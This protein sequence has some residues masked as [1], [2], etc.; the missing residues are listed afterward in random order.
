MALQDR[1]EVKMSILKPVESTQKIS[2]VGQKLGDIWE[3]EQTLLE[4]VSDREIIQVDLLF[5]RA[6]NQKLIVYLQLKICYLLKEFKCW[7]FQSQ[8]EEQAIEGA[9]GDIRDLQWN[10]DRN[11]RQ[12]TG[13]NP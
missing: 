8:V 9:S 5:V 4:I 2:I 10:E 3:T 7:T 13:I 6:E 12:S 1:Y 11:S